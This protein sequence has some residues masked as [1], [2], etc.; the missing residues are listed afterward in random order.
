MG[1][2]VLPP[3]AD[4]DPQKFIQIHR[5]VGREGKRWEGRREEREERKVQ[6]LDNGTNNN[7]YLTL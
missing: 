5:E 3:W 1:D 2:V 6:E 7:I 4:N